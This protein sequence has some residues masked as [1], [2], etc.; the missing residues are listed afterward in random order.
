[1]SEGSPWPGSGPRTGLKVSFWFIVLLTVAAALV[2]VRFAVDGD[3]PSALG[4]GAGAVF[5]GHLAGFF[6]NMWRRPRRAEPSSADGAVMFRYSGWTYYWATSFMVLMILALL[7]LGWSFLVAGGTTGVVVG[8]GACGVALL[9]ALALLRQLYGGYGWLRL[10]PNGPEHHGL[11][12]THRL[13]WDSVAEVA[14]STLDDGS[15]LILILPKEPSPPD[16]TFALPTP[17][18]R[19]RAYLLPSMAIRT[20]WLADD[21][22]TVYQA[23]RHYHANP[24]HRVELSTGAALDRIRQRRFLL[25]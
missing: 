8:I 10:T 3:V 6:V 14:A 19:H 4:F 2:A 23:L 9:L 20:M 13:P 12:F 7:L 11:G 21:P 5:F 22:A 17:I 25:R 16:V 18:G 24:E 1:M 15:R